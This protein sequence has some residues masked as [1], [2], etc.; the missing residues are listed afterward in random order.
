VTVPVIDISG[1]PRKVAAEVGAAC[2]EL[3]FLT[4]VGHGVPDDVAERAA[5]ATHAFFDLPEAEKR[6][7]ADGEPV[8]GLPAYRPLRSKRSQVPSP[9]I[10]AR[11]RKAESSTT[12]RWICRST[13]RSKCGRWT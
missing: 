9:K 8:L 1:D 2:G 11:R 12:R 7:L 4:V 3:G 6:A 5:S 13:I 10:P